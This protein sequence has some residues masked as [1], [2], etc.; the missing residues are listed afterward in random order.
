MRR[1]VIQPIFNLSIHS[2]IST[3][4]CS[5]TTRANIYVHLQKPHKPYPEPPEPLGKP[6]C[7]FKYITRKGN[8]RGE[9]AM[10]ERIASECIYHRNAALCNFYIRTKGNSDASGTF[11]ICGRIASKCR[12]HRNGATTD[13]DAV[14]GT[15][16]LSITAP[17]PQSLHVGRICF[18]NDS[19]QTLCIFFVFVFHVL[20][21]SHTVVAA[22]VLPLSAPFIPA[23]LLPI[24]LAPPPVPIAALLPLPAPILCNFYIKTKGKSGA[25][26]ALVICGRIAYCPNLIKL[27]ANFL[28]L[29]TR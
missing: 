2:R 9:T 16:L 29:C 15:P 6:L 12:Y 21:T 5:I 14:S 23:P 11:V 26:G 8:K 27:H 20:T 4:Q 19:F 17:V 28:N 13:A 3:S 22:P 1:Q 25:S 18:P 24:P 10:C 7:N